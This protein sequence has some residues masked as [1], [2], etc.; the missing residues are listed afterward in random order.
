MAAGV[1]RGTKAYIAGLRPYDVIYKI[2][3]R[4]IESAAD[5]YKAINE[6]DVKE[7]KINYIREGS[8]FFAGIVR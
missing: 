2:N 1:D 7:Y 5:F 3:D 4:D 6:P 8:E